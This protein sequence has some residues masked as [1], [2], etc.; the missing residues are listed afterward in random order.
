MA[1][2]ANMN[3]LAEGF[4]RAANDARDSADLKEIE[5][6][7]EAR[8]PDRAEK[9]IGWPAMEAAVTQSVDI[10]TYDAAL[11]KAAKEPKP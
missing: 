3:A 11:R 7:I 4:I 10:S 1:K 9:A 5:A 6:A 2:N 8:D